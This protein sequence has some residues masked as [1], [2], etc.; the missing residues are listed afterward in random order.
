MQSVSSISSLTDVSRLLS[1]NLGRR[2]IILTDSNTHAH[3]LAELVVSVPELSGAEVLEVPPG[4]SSKSIEI[5]C[6]LWSAMHE[7]QLDRS[8]ILINLGGGMVTDLGGFVASTFKRGIDFIHVPTSILGM[9]DAAIGGKTGINFA[10]SKNQIGTF[11]NPLT[12]AVHK[13]FLSSLP[14]REV[15][16]GFAEMVKHALIHSTGSWQQIQEIDT[17]ESELIGD[18]ITN[19][20]QI[21]VDVVAQDFRENGIRAALNFGHTVGHGIEASWAS[22]EEPI[23]HGEAIGL[24]MILEIQIAEKMGLMIKEDSTLIQGQ[25]N[26][27]FGH[28]KRPIDHEAIW[29]KMLSDKKNKNQEIRMSLVT[30]PGKVALTAV[31]E[32]SICEDNTW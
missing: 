11:Q 13:G 8:A 18:L 1:E 31:L 15:L 14:Q 25:L 10:D 28:L 26:K 30:A 32:K 22:S 20:A 4:E 5:V 17:V 29:T 3:C 6:E 7:M 23:L 16:S 24:G 27:W 19:S 12:T 9:V 2:I 21:K